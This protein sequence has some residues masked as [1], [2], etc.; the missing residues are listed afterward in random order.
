M[1]NHNQSAAGPKQELCSDSVGHSSDFL[2]TTGSSDTRGAVKR[3]RELQQ[4][5]ELLEVL[6]PDSKAKRRIAED[7]ATERLIDISPRDAIEEMLAT[8]MLALHAAT[9]TSAGMAMRADMPWPAQKEELNLSIKASRAFAQLADTLDRRRRGGEQK[10]R[11]E[12]VHVHA[13]GQAIVGN[14]EGGGL[15]K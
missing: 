3:N 2:Q 6:A 14:V 7:A 11:V 13:G 15:K 5:L 4:V 1:T 8:Q 10:V 9:I 12:H